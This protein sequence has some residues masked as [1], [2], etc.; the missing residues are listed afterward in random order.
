MRVTITFNPDTEMFHQDPEFETEY[1]L[2]EA[3]RLLLNGDCEFHPA[4]LS[5]SNGVNV[6]AVILEDDEVEAA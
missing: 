3:Q 6:G 2:A 4:S 1:V 5:D